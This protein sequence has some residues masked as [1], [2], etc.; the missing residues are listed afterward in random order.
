MVAI[1]DVAH[2]V[3]GKYSGTV[4]TGMGFGGLGLALQQYAQKSMD[5]EM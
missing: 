5:S 2:S 1:H 4:G 3:L